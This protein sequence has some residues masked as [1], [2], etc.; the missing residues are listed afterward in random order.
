MTRTVGRTRR[1]APALRALLPALLAAAA[2]CG[3]EPVDLERDPPELELSA[4]ATLRPDSAFP[5]SRIR[6]VAVAED[7]R[8]AVLDGLTPSILLFDGEGAFLYAAGREGEGPGEFSSLFRVGFHDG[9][10]WGVDA[11][12]RS[13]ALFRDGEALREVGP[14]SGAPPGAL[15]LGLTGGD[16]LLLAIQTNDTIRILMGAPDGSGPRER[17]ALDAG[18]RMWSLT[19]GSSTS[20]N[21][22]LAPYPLVGLGQGEVVVVRRD[23]AEQ[24]AYTVEWWGAGGLAHRVAVPFTPVPVGEAEIEAALRPLAS[25]SLPEMMVRAGVFASEGEALEAARERMVVPRHLPPVRGGGSG[26]GASS[27]LVG[28]GVVWVERWERGPDGSGRWDVVDPSGLRGRVTVPD[29]VRL[30]AVEDGGAWGVVTD[31]LDLPT[32]V[33]YRVDPAARTP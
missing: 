27:V 19:P 7:G 29:T 30:V 1:P 26:L 24:P 31:A 22:P 14:G 18:D 3:G 4:A 15:P 23:A 9:M 8:V 6:Q 2:S 28:R 20:L 33:R 17:V 11:R 32:V 12:R 16:S 5:L 13:L 10:V 25:S 21:Q